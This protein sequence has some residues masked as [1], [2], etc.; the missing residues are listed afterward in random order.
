MAVDTAEKRQS[1]F[2]HGGR[3]W[4]GKAYVPNATIDFEDRMIG[5]TFYP[6]N[7]VSG[8]ALTTGDIYRLSVLA[9]LPENP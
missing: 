1:F 8:I 3:F 6:G 9:T 7:A 5:V 2:S 4:M